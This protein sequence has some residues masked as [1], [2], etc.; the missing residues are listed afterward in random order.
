MKSKVVNASLSILS[1]VQAVGPF[2]GI[3]EALDSP[4][5]PVISPPF[6][7]VPPLSAVWE[8][9][10]SERIIDLPF[11]QSSMTYSYQ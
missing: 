10:T 7:S 2:S 6:R 3:R 1:M 11:D 8:L 9:K 4:I 5:L